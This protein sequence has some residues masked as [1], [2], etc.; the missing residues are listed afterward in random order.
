MKT[1]SNYAPPV[2]PTIPV[3]EHDGLIKLG[4]LT[5]NILVYF[6][7]WEGARST[8]QYQLLFNDN[9]TG[10]RISL[11]DPV[12]EG[13][14]TLSIPLQLLE[15]EGVYKIAYVIINPLSLLEY[16]SLPTMIRIDRTAPG[17]ALLAALLFPEGNTGGAL[18]AH[19]PGYAGMAVGDTVQTLCNGVQGPTYR[20]SEED[21]TTRPM[22]ISFSRDFLQSLGNPQIEF[23]YRVA[24]RAGNQSNLAW[25]VTLVIPD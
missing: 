11:P 24:D 18:T 6:P 10:D 22:Q 12:P 16:R 3:A 17:T 1:S 13:P 2:A 4:D 9:K 7:V 14:L 21:F 8:E 20:V 25:P 15:N 23:T 19:I 5:Q